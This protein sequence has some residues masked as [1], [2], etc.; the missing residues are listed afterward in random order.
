MNWYMQIQY[1]IAAPMLLF[2]LLQAIREGNQLWDDEL[3]RYDRRLLTQLTV[4]VLLP[5]I[6]LIH[7]L[8]HAVAIYAFGG[9][10]VAFEYGLIWGGVLPSGNFTD[11]QN[12]VISGAGVGIQ[13]IVGLLALLVAFFSVSPPV[14]ALSVYLSL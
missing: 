8:G 5:I 14:V 6:V 4:F 7:E 1:L 2:S 9:K 13:V 10:V 11:W 3:T 12:L